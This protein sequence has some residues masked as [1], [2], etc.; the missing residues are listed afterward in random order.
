MGG[1]PLGTL[2]GGEVS[3]HE[4]TGAQTGSA[5][6]WGDYSSMGVD[7]TDDCTFWYTEEYYENTGSF[8]WDTRICSFKF[9]D[10][11][12]ASSCGDGVCEFG[13]DCLGC[14]ADCPSFDLPGA[15]CGNGLCEA[16]DGED[17]ITCPADCNGRQNGKPSNRYCCGFGGQNSVGCGDARCAASGFSCTETPVGSGGSTCCGDLACEIPE[18]SFS[19]G[20]DCGVPP[21][22]GDGTCDP[23]EDSCSCAVDCGPPPPTEVG[24]CTDGVDNDCDLAVDCADADCDGIDPACLPVDCSQFGDKRSCNVEP[25]C[26][27]DNRN[28][29]CV[30]I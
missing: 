23:A 18:D 10:C 1:D 30:P 29:V 9:P 3:C 26:R 20:V 4:G 8:D 7:P 28:K 17:C 22:C 21:I 2:P 12:G 27:W 5:N 14:A 25:T 24:W 16:G 19:C 15:T 11:G 13:E 6:R